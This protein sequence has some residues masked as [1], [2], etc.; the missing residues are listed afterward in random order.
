MMKAIICTKYGSPDVLQLQEVKKPEPKQDEVRI[1]IVAASVTTAETMMRKGIPYIG[2]LFIGLT[3]PKNRIPGTGFAGVVE[4]V[5]KNVTRFKEGDHVFG[6]S[7]LNF[8]TYAEYI[9]ISE[10]GIILNKPENIT[11]EEAAPICD[12]ALTSMN[13]LKDVAK[14]QPEHKILI[15]GA[16][17]SLGTA[18]VQLAKIIGANVTAVCSGA[19]I[20]LVSTLGADKVTDYTKEDFTQSNQLYD[21]IYDTVGKSSFKQSHK[22]LS[23]NGLF[24]SPVLSFPLLCNVLSTSISGSKKAKFSATGI[25]P[26]SELKSLLQATLELIEA[27]KIRTI[28]DKCYP[29]SEAAEA[30]KYVDKGHKKGNVVLITTR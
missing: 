24:I 19:N 16:S 14:L 30:H 3:K 13:F 11:F 4:S 15:N 27:E 29:L 5:G 25:R 6:E 23:K 21:V 20:D 1:R 10:T 18:A 8:G 9:C 28:I 7:T 2:R 22:Y 17:G 12:G 26:E